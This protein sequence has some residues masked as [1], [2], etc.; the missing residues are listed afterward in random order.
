MK[1]KARKPKAKQASKISYDDCDLNS[2]LDIERLVARLRE[3]PE[4]IE[5][6]LTILDSRAEGKSSW[7]E[8]KG[9]LRYFFER[10]SRRRGQ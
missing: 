9:L 3:Y 2:P 8:C 6:V 1:Q 10:R 7:W 5:T 4:R